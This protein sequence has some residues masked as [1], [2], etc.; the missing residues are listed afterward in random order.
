MGMTR[1]SRK[2]GLLFTGVGVVAMLS[3]G[4]AQAASVYNEDIAHDFSAGAL[5]G[6]RT[7]SSQIIDSPDNAEWNGF[8]IAWDISFDD[9]SDLFT[10]KYTITGISNKDISHLTIDVSDARVEG[11][12]SNVTGG[13]EVGDKDGITGALKFDSGGADGI[14]YSLQTEYRPMWGD[15]FAKDGAS[16]VGSGTLQATN[17]GF[18][19][20][21]SMNT[22]DFIAVP[23]SAKGPPTGG[24]GTVIPLP[25]A[26]WMGMVMLGGLGAV[27]KFRS[28][29]LA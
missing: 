16:Q 4:S 14:M 7:G 11:D 13:F 25:A 27:K 26:A 19:D 2:V 3:A 9:V 8:N 1:L 22:S 12:F 17:T 24:P 10:Y 21:A 28:R 29:R 5:T 20:H 6:F 15:F 23:D 18:I